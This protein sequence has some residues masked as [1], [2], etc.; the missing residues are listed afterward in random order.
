LVIFVSE[1]VLADEF[2]FASVEV[3]EERKSVESVTVDDAI[4]YTI[5]YTVPR[6]HHTLPS[7]IFVLRR[8]KPKK[9]GSEAKL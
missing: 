2:A 1:R 8:R 9:R 6:T 3:P 4:L 5:L 7:N